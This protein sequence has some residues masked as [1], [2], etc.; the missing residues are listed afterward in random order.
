MD[1]WV[2]IHNTDTSLLHYAP[3]EYEIEFFDL[4]QAEANRARGN[5]AF[6]VVVSQIKLDV[7]YSVLYTGFNNNIACS[8]YI[9]T[10]EAI[11]PKC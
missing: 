7:K 10:M 11:H 8:E 6:F 5:Q 4:Q 1:E 2:N 9:P 3:T